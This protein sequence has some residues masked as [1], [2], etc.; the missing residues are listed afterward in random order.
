MIGKATVAVVVLLGVFGI[1]AA[2]V[3]SEWA[4]L[5]V[6]A[7][8][9]L[10]LFGFLGFLGWFAN[11]HPDL[12]ATEGTTYVQSRQ[13]TLGAKNLPNLPSTELMPDPQNPTLFKPVG[14]E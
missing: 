11:N 14:A 2:R 4:M 13:L 1:I 5:L 6:G 12:A 7:V 9:F 10:A 3:P 8:A